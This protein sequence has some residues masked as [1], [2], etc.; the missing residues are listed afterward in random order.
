MEASVLHNRES[1]IASTHHFLLVLPYGL[2]SVASNSALNRTPSPSSDT[3][4]PN[5]FR[6]ASGEAAFLL[7]PQVT[8]F[9]PFLSW[10]CPFPDPLSTDWVL[11][12]VQMAVEALVGSWKRSCPP[13][14]NLWCCAD[15]PPPFAVP[16]QALTVCRQVDYLP[17]PAHWGA[18][19]RSWR[20]RPA[21]LCCPLGPQPLLRPLMCQEYLLLLVLG[22]A[23]WCITTNAEHRYPVLSRISGSLLCALTCKLVHLFAPSVTAAQT[24]FLV[25][26][27]TVQTPTGGVKKLLLFPSSGAWKS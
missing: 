26:C 17:A 25:L 9:Q 1:P 6:P 8:S 13:L 14:H 18:P 24:W 15:F 7:V 22:C 3:M 10:K 5:P 19:G 23:L 12:R 11:L 16:Q 4:A 27:D 2:G 21:A 20:P